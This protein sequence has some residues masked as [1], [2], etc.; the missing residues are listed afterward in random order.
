MALHFRRS[1]NASSVA[2]FAFSND[3]SPTFSSSATGTL[4]QANRCWKKLSIL[5]YVVFISVATAMGNWLKIFRFK[6]DDDSIE[7]GPFFGRVLFIDHAI[8]NVDVYVSFHF[9]ADAGRRSFCDPIAVPKH[10][11]A[12][13]NAGISK[14]ELRL[15]LLCGQTSA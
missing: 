3:H 4:F 11:N 15:R 7:I 14:R 8:T 2:G 9:T 6:P 10:R 12:P 13:S 5:A 1:D